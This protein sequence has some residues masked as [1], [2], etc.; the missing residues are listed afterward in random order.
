MTARAFVLAAAFL[1]LGAATAQAQDADFR[2]VLD[3]ASQSWARGDADASPR[4]PPRRPLHQHRRTILGPLGTATP[5]RS[6]ATSERLG[7]AA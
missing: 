1:C 3:S 7:T 2:R 6:S 4:S 5:L